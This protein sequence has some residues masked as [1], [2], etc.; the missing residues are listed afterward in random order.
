MQD[1]VLRTGSS[2]GDK[3]DQVPAFMGLALYEMEF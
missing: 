1:T 3:S 2:V